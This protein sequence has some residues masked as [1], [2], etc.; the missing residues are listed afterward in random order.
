MIGPVVLVDRLGHEVERDLVPP[1]GLDVPVEAVVADVQRP[2]GEP[3]AVRGVPAR[4]PRSAASPTPGTS[5]ARSSQKPV[6]VALGPVVHGRV[7]DDR[8]ARRTRARA[9]TRAAPARG[10]R[11]RPRPPH[12]SP[13]SVAA[14]SP[15]SARPTT[16]SRTRPRRVPRTFFRPK[17]RGAGDDALRSGACAACGSCAWACRSAARRSARARRRP[18]R[19]RL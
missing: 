4:A 3:R 18:S 9:G 12:G 6:E 16:R 7:G 15:R 17:S 1:P 13:R 11:W 8:V 2:V 19:P 10:R 14:S 5:L